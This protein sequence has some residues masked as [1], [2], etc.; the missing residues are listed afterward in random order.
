MVLAEKFRDDVLAG[1]GPLADEQLSIAARGQGIK[2]D[3][4]EAHRD[5]PRA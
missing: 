5:L 2:N 1:I 4:L 3:K